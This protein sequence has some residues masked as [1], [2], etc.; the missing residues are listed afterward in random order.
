[1][2]HQFWRL[3]EA[4]PGNLGVAFTDDGLLLGRTP[5]IERRDRRF[6]VRERAE[7]E[8]LLK[9]VLL[10][11][12]TIDRLMPGLATVASALNADDPCLA[13]IAAVHLKI[14]DIPSLSARD[15]MEVEDALIRSS[16]EG[17]PTSISEAS[18]FAQETKVYNPAE[19]RV[20]AGSG[21]VSGEWT[22]GFSLVEELSESAA[23]FLSRLAL[24]FLEPEV[25]A[26][27][28]ALGLLFVPSPNDNRVEGE[29]SG[30]PGLT[31]T[32]NH[33]ETELH[34]TYDD[35]GAVPRTF[36]AHLEDDQFVDDQG[37]V[38]G[39]TLPGRS[40]VIDPAAISSDL[41]DQD[42]PKLCPAPGPDNPAAA[43]RAEITKIM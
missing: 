26:A 28:V 21:A 18:D 42:E 27:A 6:I 14:P 1:V 12:T 4:G 41:V 15:Q 2:I 17:P 34:F 13:R 20:P 31:Y 24:G 35:G 9:H 32:W 19:P 11:D 25:G 33:D 39:R 23:A 37:R 8:K 10:K 3:S 30:V 43:S 40:V 7:I 5:L 36:T 22:R 29:V 16:I 38:V